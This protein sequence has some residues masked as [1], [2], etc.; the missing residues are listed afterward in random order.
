M[1]SKFSANDFYYPERFI[2]SFD[3]VDGGDRQLIKGMK[4]GKESYEIHI[5]INDV[6]SAVTKPQAPFSHF[7][8]GHMQ[9]YEKLGYHANTCDLLRG[10]IASGCKL[11]VHRSIDGKVIA[12][13]IQLKP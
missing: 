10:F 8:P 3:T 12:T 2:T 11:I 7:T 4:I 6:W 9:S 1:D 5:A 13:E